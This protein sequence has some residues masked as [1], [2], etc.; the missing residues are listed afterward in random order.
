[1]VQ[2]CTIYC[3]SVKFSDVVDA[4]TTLFDTASV[5][6][7][8]ESWSSILLHGHTGE[9]RLAANLIFNGNELLNV[10]GETVFEMSR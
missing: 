2:N 4:A 7:T 10:S 3:R 1:M 5:V 6:G 8:R 9:M